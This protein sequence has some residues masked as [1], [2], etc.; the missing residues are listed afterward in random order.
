VI[1]PENACVRISHVVEVDTTYLDRV[2]AERKGQPFLTPTD[3]DQ[4]DA[5]IAAAL[6]AWLRAHRAGAGAPSESGGIWRRT[7]RVEGLR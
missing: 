2:L 7:G 6:A 3:R 1:A 4:D 5:A